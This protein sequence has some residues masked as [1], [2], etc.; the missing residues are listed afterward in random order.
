MGQFE[1]IED[2]R[3][4]A[5][6]WAACTLDDAQIVGLVLAGNDAAFEAL[7]RRYNRLLFRLARAILHNDSDAQD[8]VQDSYVKAFF[9]LSQFRGPAGFQS[10]MSRIVINEAISSLRGVAPNVSGGDPDELT[11]DRRSR[12][13]EIAMSDDTVRLIEAAVDRLPDDFRVVFMLRGIEQLTVAE[14]A[15]ILDINPATVKTRFFRA[16]N[17]IRR[18]LTRRIAGAVPD[19]FSFAGERCDR[20]VAAVFER[21]AG[22]RRRQH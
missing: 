20:I 3:P 14:T 13:E 9:R 15:E 8:V 5:S 1:S 7:M 19:S 10:W 21:T 16:R 2:Y 4:P 22:N 18:S 12:P 11:N 6:G 17:L